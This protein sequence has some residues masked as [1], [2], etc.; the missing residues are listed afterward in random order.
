MRMGIITRGVFSPDEVSLA[1]SFDGIIEQLQGG[2]EDINARWDSA[3]Q[4]WMLQIHRFAYHQVQCF[5]ARWLAAFQQNSYW[6]VQKLF[7]GQIVLH[8]SKLFCKPASFG[9][10][11]PMHQDWEYFP[12]KKDS[13]IA[14]LF[15]F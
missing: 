3:V 13:M 8:H 4:L 6:I 1:S 2:G 12:M 14:E 9:A 11:F 10:P 5:D 7:W 15:M